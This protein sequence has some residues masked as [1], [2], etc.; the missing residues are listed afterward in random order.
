MKLKADAGYG[1]KALARNT[2]H[3]KCSV[4]DRPFDSVAIDVR[5][6]LFRYIRLTCTKRTTWRKI[7]CVFGI[8]VGGKDPETERVLQDAL[9]TMKA[10]VGMLCVSNAIYVL[11]SPT[12][13]P[14]RARTLIAERDAQKT[15][16]SDRFNECVQHCKKNP[17]NVRKILECH[18][19]FETYLIT[20]IETLCLAY[21]DTQNQSKIDFGAE[22]VLSTVNH[23]F[24]SD[25]LCAVL[26]VD[27]VLSED[28]DCVA[29]FGAHVIIVSV[30][31]DTA[32]YVALSDVLRT[33]LCNSRDELV[34]KCCLMG[35]DY[36][37]GMK[38]IGPATIQKIDKVLAYNLAQQCM[39]L[40]AIDID[41]INHF[42]RIA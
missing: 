36:N 10:E 3:R 13:C 4:T 34:N 17:L 20:H 9:A 22:S 38:G 2:I 41:R 15:R 19:A 39:S 37:L 25:R 29:L 18:K 24:E 31:H 33:F 21:N 32:S 23:S 5:S 11:C 26:E 42:F 12:R 27:A 8:L 40:Q 30:D 16:A 7:R 6:R 35:T 14:F 1:Y 28:F